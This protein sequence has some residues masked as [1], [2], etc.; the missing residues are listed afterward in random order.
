[1]VE[2]ETFIP[3]ETVI[4]GRTH[5]LKWPED[6]ELVTSDADMGSK[7]ASNLTFSF[8]DY[9]KTYEIGQTGPAGGIVFYVTAGGSSGL[10]AAPPP[11]S[12]APWLA[13]WSCYSNPFDPPSSLPIVEWSGG[14]SGTAVGTGAQNTADIVESCVTMPDFEFAA[15]KADE[16]TLN[17]FDDWFL[18]SKDALRQMYLNIGQGSSTGNV[19][20]L[21]KGMY[22]S[23]TE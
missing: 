12:L 16:Y 4:M 21:V 17:G 5:T 11:G 18:P 15:K 2:I 22:W 6:R 10:E 13:P 3:P 14:V 19:G 23:S 1:M 8:A 7:S 20:G 9:A